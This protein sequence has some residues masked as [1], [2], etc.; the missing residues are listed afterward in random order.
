MGYGGRHGR[1][2]TREAG[3]LEGQEG[4]YKVAGPE[5]ITRGSLPEFH[6]SPCFKAQKPTLDQGGPFP[7]GVPVVSM[8]PTLAW[9]TLGHVEGMYPSPSLPCI[10]IRMPLLFWGVGDTPYSVSEALQSPSLGYQI[11]RPMNYVRNL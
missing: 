2:R 6:L 8:L 7:L 5:E 4:C 3:G 10:V 1:Y 9:G 11:F